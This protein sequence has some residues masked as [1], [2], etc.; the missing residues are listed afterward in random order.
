MKQIREFISSFR[1]AGSL[2][3]LFVL[4]GAL[5]I[6]PVRADGCENL[7][8]G[9]NS[10]QGCTDC[11]YCCSWNNGYHCDDAHFDR[12]CGTGGPA[13]FSGG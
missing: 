5:W 11:H 6:T 12:D 3:A 7:C 1:L 8:W 10:V 4:L 13:P 2:L 9:W